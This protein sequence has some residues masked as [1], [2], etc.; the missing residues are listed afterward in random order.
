[1]IENFRS[2]INCKQRAL[3]YLILFLGVFFPGTGY[4][5]DDPLLA[6]WYIGIFFALTIVLYEV[7]RV[8][9][10]KDE[11]ETVKTAIGQAALVAIAGEC[12]YAL[13]VSLLFDRR[14]VGTMN[15]TT[16][17][18]LCITLLLPFVLRNIA[19]TKSV[20]RVACVLVSLIAVVIIF[21]TECRTGMLCVAFVLTAAA[22]WKYRFF[23]R[24]K[25]VITMTSAIVLLFFFFSD[26]KR[27]STT[28]RWFILKNSVELI[29]EKPLCGYADDGGFR[30]VYMEKQAEYFKLNGEDKYAVLADDISHPL[31]EFVYSWIN[32]GVSGVAL[33]IAM[34]SFPL[35]FFYR[36]ADFVGICT[37]C[38]LVVFCAFSN[39]LQYPLPF[40][41][42]LGCNVWA[43]GV[44]LVNNAPRC[45]RLGRRVVLFMA[46]ALFLAIQCHL[47]YS[48]FHCYQW[49]RAAH[50]AMRGENVK[51]LP[52][53]EKLY[54]YF[55]NDIYFLYNYMSE[56]YFA[57][58]FEKALEISMEL[59][60]KMSSYN[61]ELLTGDIYK[62][63]GCSEQAISYYTKA[64]YM[65]PNRFAPLEGLYNA[66]DA[67]GDNV[68]KRRI[69]DMIA[70]KKIKIFSADVMRIKD[71]CR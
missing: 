54:G 45:I 27:D 38:T 49:N 66:Y 2:A 43:V 31:N 8:V 10:E 14:L 53:F 7:C 18:A 25:L 11:A 23:K 55:S 22:M 69:A 48:F 6:Q 28:G 41:F 13:S 63:L 15:S 57:G 62:Q 17:L 9:C 34:L 12:V 61:L 40:L 67:M 32:Y 19:H 1:M 16:G 64:S 5:K 46:V 33:L 52:E 36:R 39:P 59:H 26:Y 65:C 51:M 42:L 70:E 21:M 60:K 68:N 29:T 44:I 3:L 58:E 56:L 71:S 37:M 4:F 35:V 50:K 30:K 20:E 24:S 47:I